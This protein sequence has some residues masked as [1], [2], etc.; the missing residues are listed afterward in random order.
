MKDIVPFSGYAHAAD[1]LVIA[2]SSTGKILQQQY[3]ASSLNRRM[4]CAFRIED[5]AVRQ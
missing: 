1:R 2:L 5:M 3:R 4:A